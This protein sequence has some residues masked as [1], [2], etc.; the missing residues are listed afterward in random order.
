M[1]SGIKF[2]SIDFQKAGKYVAMHLT[3]EEQRRSPKARILPRR[4]T[5]VRGVHPGVSSNPNNVDFWTFPKD[6]R[7]EFEERMLVAMSVQIGVIAV[8]NTYWTGNCQPWTSRS[9]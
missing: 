9:G 1:N 7:T 4:K 6:E 2:K 8:M 3:E 5:G